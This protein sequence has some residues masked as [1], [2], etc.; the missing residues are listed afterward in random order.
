MAKSDLIFSHLLVVNKVISGI[1]I[2]M[3]RQALN[4]LILWHK[5]KPR[6]PLVLRG[7]RQ[8]GKSTLVR[9]LAENLELDLL[10]I[11]LERRPLRSIDSQG[12]E[13]DL[14]IQEIEVLCNKRITNRSLIFIDEIQAQPKMLRALRYFYEERPDLAVISA[15][16]LLDFALEQTEQIPVGRIEYYYLG[17]MKFSEFLEALG[18]DLI[19]EYI[20]NSNERFLEAV[21]ARCKIFYRQFLFVGGMPEAVATYIRTKSPLEVRRVQES[22]VATYRDDFGKYSKTSQIPRLRKFFDFVPGHLGQKLK[23]TE[24]DR[25]ERSR[26]LKVALDLLIKARVIVPVFHTNAKALPLRSFKDSD[27]FKLYFLDVGLVNAVQGVSWVDLVEDMHLEGVYKGPIAEQFVAQH[28]FYSG[29]G[30]ME[31]ELFYWLRDKKKQNAE[32]DFIIQVNDL[33]I[34]VEVKAEAV[35]KI[36]SL[37]V[38]MSESKWP[39]AARMSLELSPSE[40]VERK[41]KGSPDPAVFELRNVPLYLVEQIFEILR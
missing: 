32:V 11:N 39:V 22:I 30:S 9:Q 29:S 25:E 27:V 24:V 2:Y 26:D 38:F 6:K 1:I 16:S 35:G 15:G 20:R 14:I 34:P 10:E 7:A 28:L 37:L 3:K 17:P 4:D 18:E 13:L 5:K 12:F 33:V 19:V 23:Y 8:V 36:R 21:H 31:P 40:L 41:V